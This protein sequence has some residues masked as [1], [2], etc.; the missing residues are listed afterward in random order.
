MS[1]FNSYDSLGNYKTN[2]NYQEIIK[3]DRLLQLKEIPHTFE[4]LMDGWQIC[5]P[6]KGGSRVVS[7]IEHHGSYGNERD[8]LEIM[9]LLT[10]E[11]EQ[12]DEVVGYLTSQNV[13]ERI[14][15]H[16]NSS[17]QNLRSGDVQ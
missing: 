1:V 3:L 6:T 4:R 2:W 8:L 7:V 12:D 13:Y 5:Y 14:L 16:W 15:A 11:E 10:P 9:G 17:E